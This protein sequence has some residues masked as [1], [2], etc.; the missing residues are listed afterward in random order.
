MAF[1]GLERKPGGFLEAAVVGE[2][3]VDDFLS[4]AVLAQYLV[5]TTAIAVESAQTTHFSLAL[6]GQDELGAGRSRF[7]VEGDFDRVEESCRGDA[8]ADGQ[9][10]CCGSD[11]HVQFAHGLSFSQIVDI[12]G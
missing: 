12:R 10:C 6:V 2:A 9:D 1:A 11:D 5:G 7:G 3:G 4:E 8:D